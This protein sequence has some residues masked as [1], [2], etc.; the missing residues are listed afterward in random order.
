VSIAKP[1]PGAI[2]RFQAMERSAP[3]W[4]L[5]AAV[6]ALLILLPLAWLV[7]VSVGSERGVTF[8]HY[9]RVFADPQLQKA[10]WN[11]VV[12]A[13]WSGLVSVAIGAPMAWLSARTDLPWSRVIR[14][15]IM[16]SFVTPPFLGAFAWVML[17]GP[18]AGYINKL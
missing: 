15:L 11:T 1:V 6:L 14:S 5:T 16:A 8:A 2:P 10:L 17:A 9:A 12:L 7:Y 13:F 18:N 3:V 4:V